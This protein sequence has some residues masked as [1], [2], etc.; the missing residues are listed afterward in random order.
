MAV[1]AA[2]IQGHDQLVP[3]IN[4]V[5]EYV[6][7]TLRHFSE[8]RDYIFR[9]RVKSIES[10]AEKLETGRYNAWSQVDDLYACTIV[11]PTA[12]HEPSVRTF[13]ESLFEPV[14]LRSRDTTAKPPDV[15]RFDATRYIMRL[16]PIPAVERP[17]GSESVLFEVQIPSIF[18]CNYSGSGV[19]GNRGCR[20]V[21]RGQRPPLPPSRWLAG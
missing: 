21:D 5:A 8:K 11:I 10:L 15:F 4:S 7:S 3:A 16:R 9:D 2:V 1:P 13:L 17:P 12:D 6:G 18:Q 20:R 19:V 14:K